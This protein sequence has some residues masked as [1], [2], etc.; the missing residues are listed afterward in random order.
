G[1]A[2]LASDSELFRQGGQSRRP[3]AGLLDQVRAL[4]ERR[5]ARAAARLQR[6]LHQRRAQVDRAAG[7]QALQVGWAKAPAAASMSRE[8][9]RAFAHV[10]EPLRPTAWAKSLRCHRDRAH[11]AGDF[12]HP[13][14]REARVYN[15][16]NAFA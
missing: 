9:A 11:T 16:S 15:P 13:T 12:A 2:A 5:L 14:A 3:G 6:F 8:V 1:V 10:V 4:R 7:Q